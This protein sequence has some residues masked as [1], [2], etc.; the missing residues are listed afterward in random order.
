MLPCACGKKQ[1]LLVQVIQELVV[2]QLMVQE[3]VVQV[4]MVQE[5]VVQELM[6]KV[7]DQKPLHST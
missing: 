4:S 2:Q 1:E 7:G 5:S 3:A 6:M